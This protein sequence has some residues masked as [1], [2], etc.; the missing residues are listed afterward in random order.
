MS[1][2]WFKYAYNDF[3]PI[4]K[5]FKL[6]NFRD[7]PEDIKEILNNW[8]GNNKNSF[9][10][11]KN[12]NPY[13]VLIKDNE[14][15]KEIDSLETSNS[16][17]INILESF[18]GVFKPEYYLHNMPEKNFAFGFYSDRI[19]D[20][21]KN[22]F[23]ENFLN[24]SYPHKETYVDYSFIKE[25]LILNEFFQNGKSE[26]TLKVFRFKIEHSFKDYTIVDYLEKIK[27]YGKNTENIKKIF[28]D[29]LVSRI[30]RIP[31]AKNE[32]LHSLNLK[33]WNKLLEFSLTY[34][35]PQSL[36][37]IKNFIKNFDKE[38]SLTS[39]EKVV[40]NMYYLLSLSASNTKN[41]SK[42]FVNNFELGHKSIFTEHQLRNIYLEIDK[43][44][45]FM[46]ENN[47]RFNF[48]ETVKIFQCL[49][50]V[51]IWATGRNYK[52]EYQFFLT[53]KIDEGIGVDILKFIINIK[54]PFNF[55]KIRKL[56]NKIFKLNPE[57]A[58]NLF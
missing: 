27:D 38:N 52:A 17:K 57:L 28:T 33:Q 50:D 30:G 46:L 29:K 32:Y 41:E 18:Q 20:F 13:D 53:E 10:Y 1:V 47:R 35:G 51:G 5:R 16:S 45:N 4:E 43:I 7:F 49:N 2:D 34:K 54:K 14:L 56:D 39:P 6:C 21:H 36:E 37:N 24:M 55:S 8:M 42:N 31:K 25:I 15:I 11:R 44:I 22:L 40:E 9:A 23:E 48:Y 12:F 3:Y 19:L 58:L 26:E